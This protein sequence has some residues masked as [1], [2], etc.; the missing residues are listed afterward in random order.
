VETL[1]L[2]NG[3]FALDSGNLMTLSGP[4]KIRQ[5]LAL[6]LSEEFG[7]DRFHPQWGSIIKQYLGRI[8]NAQLQMMVRAEVLRVVKNYI[9]V[10]RTEVLADT[11]V[12]IVGR[13]DTSDVVRQITSV[14][15]RANT[16]T[17][18]V[19]LTLQTLSR[20][21]VTIRKQLVM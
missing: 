1:G 17:I 11:V 14:D 3:D 13:F 15:T 19:V 6:A 8:V 16:D 12:D 4:D 9:A 20:T 18:N 7:A 10:Q 5:D 21:Q 2:I